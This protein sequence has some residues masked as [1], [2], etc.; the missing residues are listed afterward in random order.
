MGLPRPRLVVRPDKRARRAALAGVETI[1]VGGIR[2][3]ASATRFVAGRYA[4]LAADRVRQRVRRQ[5]TPVD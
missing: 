4:G 5:S 3:L 2:S 1:P